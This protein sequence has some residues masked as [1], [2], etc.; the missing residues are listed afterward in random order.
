[1]TPQRHDKFPWT[2][3]SLISAARQMKDQHEALIAQQK[4]PAYLSY[5]KGYVAALNDLIK[6]VTK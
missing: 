1:M 6:K 4:D 5:L 2:A 3:Q